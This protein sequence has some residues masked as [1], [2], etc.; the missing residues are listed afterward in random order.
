MC[1]CALV[2]NIYMEPLD[3]VTLL[4]P[5]EPYLDGAGAEVVARL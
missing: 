5:G 3:H 1:S 2:A 4:T